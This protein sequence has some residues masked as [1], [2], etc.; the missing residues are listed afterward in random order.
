MYLETMEELSGFLTAQL[1]GLI[2]CLLYDF[3]KSLKPKTAKK[4]ASDFFD[5]AA[6]FFTCTAFFILW[7]KLLL[8]EYRWYT[9]LASILAALLYYL[10]IH[11]YVFTA[12]CIIVK[13][14]YLF[15]HTIFKI[16]LTVGLFLGKISMYISLICK[17]IYN[18]D[19]EGKAYEKN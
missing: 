11:R 15:L 10:T 8:G 14:I 9:V 17:K 7:Q 6:W 18:I 1:I 5:A 12:Y 2:I 13:K 4:A 16:L 19:C 3:L